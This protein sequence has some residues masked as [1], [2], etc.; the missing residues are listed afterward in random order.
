ML[1]PD[2]NNSPDAPGELDRRKPHPQNPQPQPRV[3]V[4]KWARG[5]SASS[6]V[7]GGLAF[8]CDGHRAN[9]LS[10]WEI[11]PPELPIAD[12]GPVLRD[13]G[14]RDANVSQFVRTVV[15]RIVF[16]TR[17]TNS[18]HR[19]ELLP[20]VPFFEEAL[21]ASSGELVFPAS[22]ETPNSPT[23]YVARSHERASSRGSSIAAGSKAADTERRPPTVPFGLPETQTTASGQSRVCDRSAATT[24]ATLR[25][26]CSSMRVLTF[27]WCTRLRVTVTRKELC[28][29]TAICERIGPFEKSRAR[30]IPTRRGYTNYYAG[31]SRCS[32]RS[33]SERRSRNNFGDLQRAGKGI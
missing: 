17:P 14:T 31:S 26:I 6:A 21:T 7:I 18:A 2:S 33:S 13:D 3:P 29:A 32:N 12:R 23:S 15:T 10:R 5:T 9:R 16:A 24:C 30:P 8:E 11:R 25:F 1:H 20:L 4:L 27:P 22:P 19:V 28:S